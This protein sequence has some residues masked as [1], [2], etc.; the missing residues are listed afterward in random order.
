MRTKLAIFFKLCFK[1]SK[2]NKK[3]LKRICTLDLLTL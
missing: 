2:E 1:R 3:E